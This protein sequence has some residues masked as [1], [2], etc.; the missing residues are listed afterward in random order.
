MRRAYR[1]SAIRSLL[2]VTLLMAGVSAGT[3]QAAS[4]DAFTDFQTVSNAP[5]NTWSYWSTGDTNVANYASSIVPMP[6]SFSGTCGFGTGC[7]FNPVD[8]GDVLQNNTGGSVSFQ[9]EVVPNGIL[10]LYPRASIALVRFRA[11][12][13]GT[14]QLDGFFQAL[15]NPQNPTR[16]AVV[17]DGHFAGAPV[18]SPGHNTFG[19]RLSFDFHEVL[20]ASDTVDF[21]AFRPAASGNFDNM[22]ATGFD[23]TIRSTPPTPTSSV[24]EPA[25]LLLVGSGLAALVGR[26]AGRKHRQ[27]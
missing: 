15:S 18:D 22:G 6:S 17:V 5:A 9:T 25:T 13:T 2:A 12:A 11:P 1:M 3:A 7:W 20:N 24:P 27:K 23:V 26:A 19:D 4:F 10:A 14:Y 21:L 8:R 16:W